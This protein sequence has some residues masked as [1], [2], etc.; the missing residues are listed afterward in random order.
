MTYIVKANFTLGNKTYFI[1]ETFEE[2]SFANLAILPYFLQ[3]DSV[4]I[5]KEKPVKKET[6]EKTEQKKPN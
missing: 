6:V 3:N 5:L 2:K 1:G 4:E